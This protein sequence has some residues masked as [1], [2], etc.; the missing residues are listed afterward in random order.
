MIGGRG[1]RVQ[2]DETVIS[3]GEIPSNHSTLNDEF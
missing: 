2:V 3:R 1:V